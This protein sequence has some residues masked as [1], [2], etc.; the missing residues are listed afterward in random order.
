MVHTRY[1]QNSSR[2]DKSSKGS[3]FRKALLP[4][5]ILLATLS[6]VDT[7]WCVYIDSRLGFTW[8]RLEGEGTKVDFEIFFPRSHTLAGYG[9]DL[10]S[11]TVLQLEEPATLEISS[12]AVENRILKLHGLFDRA[13]FFNV[14]VVES[15]EDPFSYTIDESRKYPFPQ[16]YPDDVLEFLRPGRN[17]E[18][19]RLEIRTLAQELAG[20]FADPES[21]CMYRA[22][23]AIINSG[24]FHYMPY[25]YENLEEVTNGCV[26]TSFAD[27]RVRSAFEVYQDY[28]GVCSSKARLGAALCRSIGIPARTVSKTGLHAWTEMW[29]NGLGWV[30][31]EYTG[32]ERFPKPITGNNHTTSRLST[33]DD[34]IWF[35]WDPPCLSE[36]N[37]LSSDEY[38]FEF[39]VASTIIAHPAGEILH[40]SPECRRAFIPVALR[41]GIYCV[42]DEKGLTLYTL[43][44]LT[45]ELLDTDILPGQAGVALIS[46]SPDSTK[47]IQYRK[48]GEYVILN[49]LS[50]PRVPASE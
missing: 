45:G 16:A 29:I 44:V 10:W 25:D 50:S 46:I 39:A 28:I 30:P 37:M 12:D 27:G 43:N 19:D 15:E 49:I 3:R 14:Q 24:Y 7:A 9:D 23:K 47:S 33:R 48:V 5:V 41:I 18:S 21:G 32:A 42:A 26:T 8:Q 13:R 38:N 17:I 31:A 6:I 34:S 2:P 40:D 35:T 1:Q 36:F 22:V 20:E 4:L 11:F